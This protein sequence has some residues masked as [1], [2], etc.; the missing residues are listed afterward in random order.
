MCRA[1]AVSLALMAAVSCTPASGAGRPQPG[2]AGPPAACGSRSDQYVCARGRD[3]VDRAQGLRLVGGTLYPDVVIGGRALRGAAW[4]SSTSTF[5]AYIDHWL[6]AASQN[7]MNTVRP[8]D[9]LAG[10]TDWRDAATWRNLDHLVAAAGARHMLVIMDLSA[11]RNFLRRS[12]RLPYDIT[13]WISF[14]DFVGSRYALAPAIAYYS[15]AGEIEPPNGD[16]PARA[17]PDGYVSFFRAVLARLHA[18]DRGHHLVSAG[19]LNHLQATSGIPWQ[20][21]FDLPG[22]D[23]AALHVYS[24]DDRQSVVPAVS[25]WAAQQRKPVV[26]EEFGFQQDLGD[27]GRAAAFRDTY[28]L[29]RR[30][31]VAGVVF[32]NLGPQ[33]SPGSYD[34]GPD[35]PA[36]WATVAQYASMRS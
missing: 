24:D 8:T 14:L 10:V 17:T 9:F 5:R 19:G 22:A 2:G 3:L 18:A 31:G 6:D 13:A 36:V 16:D 28:E 34:V 20:T 4:A 11:Y 7:G 30:S 29:G 27:E 21:L 25:A 26:I 33:L 12:G 23:L 15:V 1:V 32:W 35:T